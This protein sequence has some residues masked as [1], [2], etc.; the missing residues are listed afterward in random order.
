MVMT[1]SL[2]VRV[3]E[4]LSHIIFQ[5]LTPLQS[6][7]LQ[8]LN[9]RFYNIFIPNMSKPFRRIAARDFLMNM[10]ADQTRVMIF[11]G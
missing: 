1:F 3:V 10:H 11:E 2:E 5:Y 4:N 6:T 7:T 9:R 8:Q